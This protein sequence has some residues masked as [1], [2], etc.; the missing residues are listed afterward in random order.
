MGISAAD[1]VA[2]LRCPTG[3]S[4]KL[5]LS[6]TTLTC[7]ECGKKYSVRND[8]VVMLEDSK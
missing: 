7:Q 8:I 5:T 3:D 2:I 1:L 6:E 4:G